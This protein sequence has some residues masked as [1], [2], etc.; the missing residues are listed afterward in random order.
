MAEVSQIN[1]AARQPV[2]WGKWLLIS[3]GALISILLL[4]VPMASIFWE[5]LNQGSLSPSAI[6]Q[7]RTCCTPSG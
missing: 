1:H 5:A 6:W 7:T 4:V 2:N 3:I